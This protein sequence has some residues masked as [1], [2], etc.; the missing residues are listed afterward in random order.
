M[1]PFFLEFFFRW[2]TA[3]ERPT[4]STRWQIQK[5]SSST[6]S[7]SSSS[8][9]STRWSPVWITV[10]TCCQSFSPTSPPCFG[11]RSIH[12]RWQPCRANWIIHTTPIFTAGND[13]LK[14]ET[15]H[16]NWNWISLRIRLWIDAEWMQHLLVPD[17]HPIFLFFLS[18]VGKQAHSLLKNSPKRLDFHRVATKWKT[19]KISKNKWLRIRITFQGDEKNWKKHTRGNR[20]EFEKADADQ[21]KIVFNVHRNE[22]RTASFFLSTVF[23]TLLDLAAFLDERGP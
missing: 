16:S 6:Y 10:G 14:K 2:T 12:P 15:S 5:C 7:S 1:H 21:Q 11:Y 20:S 3:N 17:V 13:F 9:S 18:S 4:T 8:T 23:P 22:P 19:K